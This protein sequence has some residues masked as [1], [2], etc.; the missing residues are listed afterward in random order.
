M[1]IGVCNG[2]PENVENDLDNWINNIGQ[3]C[4]WSSFIKNE[5]SFGCD[6]NEVLLF[7]S[8]FSIDSTTEINFSNNNLFGTIPAEIGDLINLD[9]INL[10]NNLL[11]GEVP[12]TIG[13]LSNLIS[14]DL[15][16]NELNGEIPDIFYNLGH[17]E[18]LRLSEN[19]LNGIIPNSICN[20]H[21][22]LYQLDLHSNN[23]CP[24]YPDCITLGDLGNQDT[25]N[26]L[27]V[28]IENE[29]YYLKI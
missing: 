6:S 21:S 14:L 1:S 5:I 13:N 15:S 7:D 12:S 20:I 10:R 18:Q 9:S 4:N 22:Q 25:S 16:N 26:C 17:L 8:C 27:Q 23:L 2:E 24:P 28:N 29:K 11:Y 3:L 19:D